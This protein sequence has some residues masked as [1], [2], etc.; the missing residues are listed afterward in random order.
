MLVQLG[1]HLLYNAVHVCAF[2]G[3]TVSSVLH[4]S[5][6]GMAACMSSAVHCVLNTWHAGAAVLVPLCHVLYTAV[7]A[8]WLF[9]CGCVMCFALYY[10]GVCG[11]I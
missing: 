9:G 2:L 5:A 1:C 10:M 8:V 6:C 11:L 3:A 7:H 4:C